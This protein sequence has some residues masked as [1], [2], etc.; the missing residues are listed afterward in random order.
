[1]ADI[2]QFPKVNKKKINEAIKGWEDYVGQY[3]RLDKSLGD[4]FSL[5]SVLG[6]PYQSLIRDKLIRN[7]P[8]T[9]NEDSE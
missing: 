8:L 7:E 1:M 3:K 6:E 5:F 4:D 2:I 9:D